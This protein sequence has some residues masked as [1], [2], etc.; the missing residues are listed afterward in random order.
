MSEIKGA[1]GGGDWG[2]SYL[3]RSRSIR[4]TVVTTSG[5]H[6]LSNF[7]PPL[8]PPSPWLQYGHTAIFWA[9]REG[10]PH[11]VDVLVAARA[12]LS[13]KTNVSPS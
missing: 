3:S 7:S 4:W 1:R 9:S 10:H 6:S 12:D 11:V 13:V 2:L 8:P 5:K